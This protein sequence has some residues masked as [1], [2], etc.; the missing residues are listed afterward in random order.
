MVCL[1]TKD[2]N[3]VLLLYR[4]H[5]LEGRDRTITA[6]KGVQN[7]KI[8][9]NSSATVSKCKMIAFKLIEVNQTAAN[10]WGA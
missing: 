6:K 1:I 7:Q 8:Y 5:L 10:Y 9:Q 3:G 2:F 4:V